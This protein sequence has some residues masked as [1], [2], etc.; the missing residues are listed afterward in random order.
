MSNNPNW[1][2]H[3]AISDAIESFANRVAAELEKQ[4]GQ[5]GARESE[6]ALQR[7][8]WAIREAGKSPRTRR[9]EARAATP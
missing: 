7:A 8:A 2:T 6:A 5:A 3:A 9:R 4:A 1:Q